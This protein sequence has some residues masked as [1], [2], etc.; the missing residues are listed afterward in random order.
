M[1]NEKNENTKNKQQKWNKNKRIMKFI[2]TYI[3]TYV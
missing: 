3:Y 1:C 2:Y